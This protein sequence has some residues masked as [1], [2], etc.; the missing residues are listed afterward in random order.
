M[1]PITRNTHDQL[2]NAETQLGVVDSARRRRYSRCVP[3]PR[4]APDAAG[5]R[6][7][8][9]SRPSLFTMLATALLLSFGLAGAAAA[10]SAT[11]SIEGVVTDPSGA[12]LPG[13]NVTVTHQAT[14]VSRETVTDTQGLFRAP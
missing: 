14:G 1:T 7:S 10:Q 11:G 5:P 6:G 12:I 3:S 2:K 9:M 8:P 4:I 13:V